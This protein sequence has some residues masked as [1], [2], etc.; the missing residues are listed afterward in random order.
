MYA[1]TMKNR[2]ITG[3]FLCISIPQFVLGVYT[4][5]LAGKEPGSSFHKPFSPVRR[6]L[7]IFIVFYCCK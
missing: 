2:V 6:R 3:I 7:L 1:I 4:V 5:A